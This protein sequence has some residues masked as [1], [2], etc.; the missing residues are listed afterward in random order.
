MILF[1][2]FLLVVA[3]IRIRNLDVLCDVFRLLLS[4]IVCS[5][6]ERQISFNDKL[7]IPL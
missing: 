4:A 5:L 6:L 2:G 7:K 3:L 1:E